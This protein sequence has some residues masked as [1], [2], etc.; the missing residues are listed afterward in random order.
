M[1]LDYRY[2]SF[3]AA[4]LAENWVQAMPADPPGSD[5]KV[6]GLSRVAADNG[7]VGRQETWLFLGQGWGK[8]NEHF[9]SLLRVSAIVYPLGS[10][11]LWT[12][13]NSSSIWRRLFKSAFTDCLHFKAILKTQAILY[14]TSI[15]RSLL[16]FFSCK[17]QYI[18]HKCHYFFKD[19]III[20][21]QF[22]VS[23]Y[24]W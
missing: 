11:V 3:M 17:W 14:V 15:C 1:I 22:W 23:C 6:A 13:N 4:N 8:A 24:G 20:M 7:Q 21:Q 18:N 16:F 2:H 9:P 12:L 10:A 5:R 19:I